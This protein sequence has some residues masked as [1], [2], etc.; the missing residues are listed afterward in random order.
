MLSLKD[1]Q[2]KSVDVIKMK[3]LTNMKSLAV[4][5]LKAS[6]IMNK[7]N[8]SS[9]ALEA[10]ISPS[11]LYNIV[12]GKISIS[13]NMSRRIAKVLKINSDSLYKLRLIDDFVKS[14]DKV[15]ASLK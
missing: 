9:L 14:F 5:A 12:W 8:I 3:G 1:F 7:L 10:K 15:Q 13:E 6:I 2:R 4:E 11:Y